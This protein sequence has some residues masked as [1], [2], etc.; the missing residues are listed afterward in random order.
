MSQM[1]RM[2]SLPPLASC[3][4]SGL[5]FKPHTSYLCPEKVLIKLWELGALAS[6]VCI[7]ESMDPLDS[8]WVY[9]GFQSSELI[10]P[11]CYSSKVRI[12]ENWFVSHIWS[13]LLDV[14]IANTLLVPFIQ[15]T[16]VTMSLSFSVSKSYFISPV[17][18]F[19]K[20]TVYARHTAS[21]LPLLQSSKFR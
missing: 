13:Y 12:L 17:S 11:L 8:K 7:W 2:L 5:H 6:F 20:Y 19:H 10:L 18:A 21:I 1:Q 9:V 15:D 16:D 14:P 4:P 3:W